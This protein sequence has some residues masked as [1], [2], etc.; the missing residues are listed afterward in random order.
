MKLK[1]RQEQVKETRV[2][3]SEV[4]KKSKV[5][6]ENYS[7]QILNQTRHEP[8]F[9]LLCS[10]GVNDSTGKRQVLERVNKVCYFFSR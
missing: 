1:R 4:Q 3:E 2:N 10:K 5:G 6:V 7:Q 9:E 8:L